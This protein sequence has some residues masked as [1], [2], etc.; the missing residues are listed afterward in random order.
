MTRLTIS[1]DAVAKT[2][3]LDPADSVVR[4]DTDFVID[5]EQAAAEARI[6]TGPLEDVAL[7]PLLTW[8]VTRLLAAELLEMRSREDGA[9]G[10]FQGAGI[11][12]GK[13]LDHPARLRDEAYAALTPYL[14]FPV[15]VG[16]KSGAGLDPFV[17]EPEPALSSLGVQDALF[18]PTEAERRRLAP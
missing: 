10:T 7:A 15:G 16:D 5:S 13:A 9:T 4:A 1:A 11:T 18:G 8:A 3:R 6:K 2:A 17:A 14:R 12:L